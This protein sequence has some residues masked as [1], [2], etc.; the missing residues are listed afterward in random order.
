MEPFWSCRIS[1]PSERFVLSML[2]SWISVPLEDTIFQ[3]SYENHIYMYFLHSSDIF[4]HHYGPTALPGNISLILTINRDAYWYFSKGKHQLVTIKLLSII[5]LLN[6]SLHSINQSNE[7][8]VTKI[9]QQC[10]RRQCKSN[11]HVWT[12]LLHQMLCLNSC[13]ILSN[14][15]L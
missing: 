9:S 6:V 2:Q 3:L 14:N 7:I 10:I 12:H 8:Y 13:S 5:G 1:A 15:N 11:W 4:S